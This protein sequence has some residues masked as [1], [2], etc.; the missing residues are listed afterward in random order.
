MSSRFQSG[1]TLVE[2]A[3]AAAIVAIA[4]GTALWAVVAFARHVAQQGGPARTAALVVA[5]QTLRV[6]QDAWKY[7]SPGSAPSGSQSIT[8]P[9]SAATT[10]PAT[11]TTTVSA[12]TSPALVTVTV[13]YTPEPGR[14]GDPG[15]V[16]VSGELDAKAPLPGSQVNRPGLV[17]LPSGAP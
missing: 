4:L 2:T 14:A 10:A 5:Q 9:R 13:R 7:G 8:L 11:L 17:P 1:V 15:V 12:S 6:A 3:V 16:S